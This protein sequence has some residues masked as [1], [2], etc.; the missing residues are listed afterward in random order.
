MN[1]FSH[2]S[3]TAVSWTRREG[4]TYVVTGVDRAG[5]RFAIVTDRWL[6][7][8]GINLWRG[9]KWLLRDGKRHLITRVYN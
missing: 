4:D 7:A 5:K 3:P 9:S 6:H 8:A 2:L 1:P